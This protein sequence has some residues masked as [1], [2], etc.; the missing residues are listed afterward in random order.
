MWS[1][2]T[3]EDLSIGDWHTRSQIVQK[4]KQQDSPEGRGVD[5]QGCGMDDRVLVWFFHP[6]ETASDDIPRD[7]NAPA[8]VIMIYPIVITAEEQF[9]KVK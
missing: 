8:S 1:T 6:S 7:G 2:K 9:L 5:I 4:C 3:D